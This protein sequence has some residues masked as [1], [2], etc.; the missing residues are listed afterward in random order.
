MQNDLKYEMFQTYFGV[1]V[2]LRCVRWCHYKTVVYLTHIYCR[3]ANDNIHPYMYENRFGETTFFQY[4]SGWW[5]V[6][7]HPPNRSEAANGKILRPQTWQRSNSIVYQ[8]SFLQIKSTKADRNDMNWCEYMNSSPKWYLESPSWC[9]FNGRKHKSIWSC[10]FYD[11][12]GT[13]SWDLQFFDWNE[14]Q[15]EENRRNT[16]AN[17][18]WL[19]IF[20]YE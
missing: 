4:F 1:C 7:N 17:L 11:L 15:T 12:V 20:P 19:V 6:Q 16:D 2:N 18:T 8:P 10:L 14:T 3:N 9:F 5:N 13:N